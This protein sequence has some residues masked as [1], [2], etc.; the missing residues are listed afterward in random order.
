MSITCIS[1]W[2][3]VRNKFK[4]GFKEQIKHMTKTL[5][6]KAPLIFYY[7]ED[8]IKKMV[9]E[10]RYGMNTIFIKLDINDF[11]T[12]KYNDRL[13]KKIHYGE[14]WCPSKELWIVSPWISNIEL[15]ENRGGDFDIINPDWRGKI[16]K[17]EDNFGGTHRF[18][19]CKILKIKKI[20]VS[21]KAVHKSL[22]NQ[23]D[24]NGTIINV[25]C[26]F[27]FVSN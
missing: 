24:I 2:W 18:A 21:I 17:L 20:I 1:G 16:I 10:I 7:S 22:L 14:G 23:N 15:I 9:E 27:L 11:Y 13:Q 3:N 25:L 8:E 19:L 12:Y 26:Y 4:G 6:I 5:K